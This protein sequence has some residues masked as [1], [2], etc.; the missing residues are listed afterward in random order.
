MFERYTER[1]RRSIFFAR[2]EA[3]ALGTSEITGEELLLGILR[4]DKTVAIQL[5]PGAAEAIRKELEQLA[6]PK[7][8]RLPTSVAMPIGEEVQRALAC[9]AEEAEAMHHKHID[10]P[11]LALGLLRVEEGLAA[12]LLRKHGMV[13]ERYRKMVAEPPSEEPLSPIPAVPL[14]TSLDPAA[15]ALQRLVDDTEGRLR[16]HAETYGSQKLSS[17]GWTRK[18]ALGHLIDRAIVHQQLVTQ[19]LM[20]SRLT[21]PRFPGDDAIAVQHYADFPWAE[22]VDLW[23]L[24]NRLLI[25]TMPRIPEDKLA[26]PCRIGSAEPVPLLRLMEAYVTHCQDFVRRILARLG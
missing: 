1:A 14:G 20:E 8:E 4:E 19:A 11:H 16:A 17:N 18:D 12:K 3:S 5:N 13:Y 22:T 24:L 26:A 21:V 2:Y 10:A 7:E 25:H 23:V 6:P 9:A 15:S